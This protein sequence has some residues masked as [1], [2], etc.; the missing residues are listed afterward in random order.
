MSAIHARLLDA[1]LVAPIGP[2]H[3][4]VQRVQSYRSRLPYTVPYESLPH[5][6]LEVSQL[7]GGL[8]GIGPI[9]VAVYPIHGQAVRR[10]QAVVNDNS[11]LVTFVYRSSNGDRTML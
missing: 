3:P 8:S 5:V 2:E 9:N 6:A 11:A 10:G 7:Y 1:S 4:T